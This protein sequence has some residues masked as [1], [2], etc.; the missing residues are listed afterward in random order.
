M[1]KENCLRGLTP[2]WLS[3]FGSFIYLLPKTLN[4]LAFKSFN[5]ERTRGRLFQKRAVRSQF[6][7]YVFITLW[8]EALCRFI[9][10]LHKPSLPLFRVMVFNTIFLNISVISW[11]SVLLVEETGVSGENHRPDASHWQT[12]S[13][14]VESSTKCLI[15]IRTH[16]VGEDRY[17]L[18]R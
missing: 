13:H 17:W 3:L 9:Y 12:L 4:Y 5:Y 8:I 15:G 18:H 10:C 14:N 11:R 6:D 2:F 1:V 16:N 7:I